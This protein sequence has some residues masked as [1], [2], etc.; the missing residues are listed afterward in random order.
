MTGACTFQIEEGLDSGP[1][2]GCVTDEVRPSDTS[3]DLLERLARS[4]ARLLA[5]TMDGIEDGQL[6]A[7]PQ[8]PDGI[9]LAPKVTVADAHVDWTTPALRVDRVVRGCTPAPG[10]WTTF[11]GER[12]KLAPVRLRA[13]DSALAPGE[14]AVERKVV[15]VGTGSHAVELSEVQPQGKRMMAAVDWA[16]GVRPEPGERFGAEVASGTASGIEA[17]S[18]A[19]S[20]AESGAANSESGSASGG[21]A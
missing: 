17:A 19:E 11:R 3:G 13:G 7:V 9:S 21:A 16:R 14:I 4:G 6:V 10:A 8:P 18:G 5:A 20:E 1:V 12:V 15:R 2:F